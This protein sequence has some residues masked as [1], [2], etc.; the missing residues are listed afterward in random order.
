MES[1]ARVL[2]AMIA[3]SGFRPLGRVKGEKGPH[4]W[5]SR[6]FLPNMVRERTSACSENRR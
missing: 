2:I 3:A 5:T 4:Q 1:V 6:G